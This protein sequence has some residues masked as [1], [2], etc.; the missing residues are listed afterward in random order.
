MPTQLLEPKSANPIPS[1]IDAKP[2]MLFQIGLG[3]MASKTLLS[4]VELGLFAELAK[5][6][7]AMNPLVTTLGLLQ[8]SARDFLDAL[9]ALKVLDRTDGPSPIYSNSPAAAA[10]LDPAKPSYIGGMFQMA[11]E[12]L[13]P[14]WGKLTE[15]LRTG[16]PQG[17]TANKSADAA[18]DAIYDTEAHV[19]RFASAMTGI[20]LGNANALASQLPWEKFETVADIGCAQGAVP[21]TLALQHP[22]LRV[23]GFDLPAVA[24]VFRK[25]ARANNVR[26]RARFVGGDFFREDLP[27]ADAMIF[28]H[29]LHDWDLPTKKNAAGQSVSSAAVWRTNRHLRCDDRQRPSRKYFW[30]ADEPQHAHRNPR[31]F[32]LHRRRLQKVAYRSRLC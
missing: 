4:A 18:F 28:G 24:P 10:F 11:N 26:E 8:R 19:E 9:V 27:K 32:R 21:V 5:G 22:H 13:Y 20:S 30:P 23:I 29:I 2:D 6:P 1:V 16:K 14:A 25:Y 15:A 12:R 3:M 17:E 7:R 31:W